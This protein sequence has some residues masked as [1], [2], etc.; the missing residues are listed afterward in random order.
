[1]KQ[2]SLR[3]KILLFVGVIIFV[4]LGSS[5]LINIL[6]LKQDTLEAMNSRAEALARGLTGN[7]LARGNALAKDYNEHRNYLMLQTMRAPLLRI[8]D[9]V[10]KDENISF[11]SIVTPSG[12]I[13]AH[14]DYKQW[15][16][17]SLKDSPVYRYIQQGEQTTVLDGDQYHS[18]IPILTKDPRVF[19]GMVD[20]GT[21][22][23]TVDRKIRH[24]IRNASLLFGLFLVLAFL[25]VSVFIH[26]V[27]TQPIRQLIASAQQLA[28]GKLVQF[29]SNQQSREIVALN[30]VFNSISEYLRNVSTISSNISTGI[31]ASDIQVRSEHDT[32]GHATRNMVRY[33]RQ[34][35]GFMTKTAE[36]DLTGTVR[37][38]STNDAFGQVI[39]T[40]TEGLRGLVE[41]LKQSAQ[42]MTSTGS[43]ISSLTKQDIKIAEQ[44]YTS[45]DEMSSTVHEMGSSIEE[46]AHNMEMLSS[47]VEETSASVTQMTT[48][49][50]HIAS[51]TK[52]LTGQT[53][54]TI[55]FLKNTIV[56]LEKVVD[57]TDESKAL[58]QMTMQDAVHGQKAVEQ[59]ITSVE[60]I[61]K[62]ITTAVDSITK[63]AQRSQDIDTIL[64]VI[65]EIT[66]QTSLLALNA[67][68]IAA[69]AGT[70]GRGFAVVADEIKNLASGVGNSTKDIATIIQ[71][72]QKDTGK[73]VQMIH[74]GAA[75]VKQG[76]ER[77]NQARE[78]LQ[79]III[80]AE[81]SSSLVSQIAET[82]H[83]LM[84]TSRQVSTSME[85]VDLMTD[86]IMRATEEQE[87]STKQINKAIAMIGDMASQI[88]QSTAEQML[89]VRQLLATTDSV[90]VLI[91]KNLESSQHIS[92]TTNALS[93]QADILMDSVG[94][95]KLPS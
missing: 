3:A 72:L 80:S 66:D 57:T 31:I 88:H 22:K 64:E 81:R 61:E 19:L 33:L 14:N 34:V 70:H 23:A 7:I 53:H 28:E 15:Q 95:F 69:Q 79:K 20:I 16:G 78:A 26:V 89:G 83:D 73:V 25:A 56:A 85:H 60:N 38:R 8:Y 36:G 58:S 18:L 75:Y 62:T 4:V 32:L 90:T 65:R 21:P 27:L 35:A 1:M 11:I 50:T 45:A 5:T 86:D 13:A 49:I 2:W 37:L 63:F 59:V 82:L 84:T 41:Q 17:K 76:I 39:L 10:N 54:H 87:S 40:M 48:S 12:V 92:H 68:I 94:R 67:S 91:E 55:A 43:E 51:K 42:Q 44:V 77:T 74:E 9:L 52:N 6:V 24:L 71:T 30:S 46:V 93:E 47:S 29:Q